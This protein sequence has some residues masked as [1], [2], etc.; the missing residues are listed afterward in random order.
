MLLNEHTILCI[1][2]SQLLYD[3]SVVFLLHVIMSIAA[4]VLC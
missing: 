2:G 3:I 1:C 4:L